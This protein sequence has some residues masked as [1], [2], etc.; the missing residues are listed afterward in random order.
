MNQLNTT[1][2]RL[3][4]ILLI[5][6]FS[7]IIYPLSAEKIEFKPGVQTVCIPKDGNG[8]T[9]SNPPCTN[10]IPVD[11][12]TPED[13]KV[14]ANVL[15]LNGWSFPRDDW[16][17]KTRIL[18]TAKEQGFRLIFPEMGKTNYESEYFPETTLKWSATPG[19][20][21]V[22]EFLIPAFQQNGILTKSNKNFVMGLSTG[23]RGAAILGFTQPEIFSA[24]ASISGD[25]DQAT[26]P[27]DRLM[28]GSY[29]KYE[30][31]KERWETVDN[32]YRNAKEWK[33]PIY[34]GHGQKDKVSPFIQTKNFYLK[35]K[36]LHPKL[37]IAFNDPKDAEHDYKY[38]DSEVDPIFQFFA[39]LK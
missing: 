15:V 3:L 14:V 32:V 7:I 20:K 25:F 31:N 39:S 8:A 1:S 12:Y 18:K 2:N 22:R 4:R 23:G 29:G 36:E 6:L 38:W 9:L 30:E 28:T 16:Q 34:L 5:I 27:K 10:K 21:W 17:K 11:V 24:A 35:L 33:I 13:K 37:K 26:M 19:G